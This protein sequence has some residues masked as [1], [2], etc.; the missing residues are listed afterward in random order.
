MLADNLVADAVLPS[1]DAAVA[2]VG[3]ADRPQVTFGT[4]PMERL[5]RFLGSPAVA[6]VLLM[7]IVGGIF[8][9]M[10]A[11]GL[12]IAG[13]VAVVGALLFFAPHY[14]LGLAE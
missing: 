3:L 12:G 14:L 13:A 8:F 6:A 7:L 10:Q 1:V 11:P 5:L 2:A 9:E 4:S